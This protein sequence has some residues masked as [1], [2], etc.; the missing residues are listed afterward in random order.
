MSIVEF[1]KDVTQRVI[2]CLAANLLRYDEIIFAVCCPP[3]T[4]GVESI[5]FDFNASP[6]GEFF[7]DLDARDDYDHLLC[8]D[9]AA[10]D[11][12]RFSF[13]AGF[14]KMMLYVF[15]AWHPTQF[16]HDKPG[17]VPQQIFDHFVEVVLDRVDVLSDHL[18]AGHVFARDMIA[19]VAEAFV[20]HFDGNFLGRHGAN[21]LG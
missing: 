12:T 13:G 14:L 8:R 4:A 11:V 19:P 7:F 2:A 6:I 10:R 21:S 16:F 5:F 18:E 1:G 3:Q 20:D 15:K 9:F 17:I